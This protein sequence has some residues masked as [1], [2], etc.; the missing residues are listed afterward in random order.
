M[1]WMQDISNK[2]A[3]NISVHIIKKRL[4]KYT[5]CGKSQRTENAFNQ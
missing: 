4:V 5:G 2:S 1:T 3:V